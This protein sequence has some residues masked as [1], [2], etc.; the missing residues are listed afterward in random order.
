MSRGVVTT[1]STKTESLDRVISSSRGPLYNDNA[2]NLVQRGL[3]RC[4]ALFGSASILTMTVTRRCEA[5][6]AKASHAASSLAESFAPV[7][8]LN[9]AQAT[10]KVRSWAETHGTGDRTGVWGISGA[11]GT[12]LSV[13]GTLALMLCC[14][15]FAIYM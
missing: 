4:T 8:D 3:C 12:A 15:M 2:A 1:H 11:A 6:Q 14:P 10:E 5:T 7:Q 13:M 9:F